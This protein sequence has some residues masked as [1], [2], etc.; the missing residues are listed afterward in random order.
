MFYYRYVL[1]HITVYFALVGH[2]YALHTS[3]DTHNLS[4]GHGMWHNFVAMHYAFIPASAS[5]DKRV[6]AKAYFFEKE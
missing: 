4:H 3:L 1:T 5:W 6:G 2:G